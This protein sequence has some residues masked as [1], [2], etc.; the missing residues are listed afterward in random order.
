MKIPLAKNEC[1]CIYNAKQT[2]YFYIR[3]ERGVGQT[4]SLRTST[5]TECAID[6]WLKWLQ[7]K[8]KLKRTSVALCNTR[9]ASMPCRPWQLGSSFRLFCSA[10]FLSPSPSGTVAGACGASPCAPAAYDEREDT[11][12]SNWEL[13]L[14]G[15]FWPVQMG[16]WGCRCLGGPPPPPRTPPRALCA[17]HHHMTYST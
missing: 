8:K 2:R 9:S 5:T 6:K 1:R 17:I 14:H 4:K 3:L 15:A 12:T 7:K 10:L 13:N 16:G 11:A